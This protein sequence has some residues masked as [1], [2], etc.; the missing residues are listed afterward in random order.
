MKKAKTTKQN[1]QKTCGLWWHNNREQ[2]WTCYI[3][4]WRQ[5]TPQ[6]RENTG[7]SDSGF[8]RKCCT[9]RHAVSFSLKGVTVAG[10]TLRLHHLHSVVIF[11]RNCCTWRHAVSCNLIG[12]TVAGQISDQ[13]IYIYMWFSVEIGALGGLL[14]LKSHRRSSCWADRTTSSRSRA[15]LRRC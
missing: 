7:Q 4:W 2:P 12:V 8:Y 10:Q 9:W 15:F 1:H 3:S 13:I 5:R 6:Q 14:C 11:C